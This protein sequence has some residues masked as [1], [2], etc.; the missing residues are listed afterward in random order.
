ML[1][2]DSFRQAGRVAGAGTCQ[3]LS[4]LSNAVIVVAIGRGSGAEGLGRFTLAFGAYLIVLGSTRALVSTP[5][6]TLRAR[7]KAGHPQLNS[8]ATA[9]IWLAVAGGAVCIL[10]GVGLRRSELVAVGLLLIPLCLQDL[11]RFAFFQIGQPWRAALVDAV[12][13]LVSLAVFQVITS[14]GSST[15]AMGLWGAGALISA[16]PG[17]RILRVRLVSPVVAYRWWRSEA[18]HLGI[19]L[20][21]ESFAFSVGSQVSLWVI[22]ALLGDGDLGRLKA[23]QTILGPAM[24]A[25]AGFTMLIVPQMAQSADRPSTGASLRMSGKALVLVGAIAGALIWIGPPVAQALF[26]SGLRLELALLIPVGAQVVAN[27]LAVGPTAAAMIHRRAG[28]LAI[29]RAVSMAIAVLAVAVCCGPLGIVGAAWALASG[30]FLFA[31]GMTATVPGA[32]RRLEG[33]AA[34]TD[35]QLMSAI[36][37]FV[38]GTDGSPLPA[39]PPD[40]ERWRPLVKK[41]WTPATGEPVDYCLLVMWAESRGVPDGV[42][43]ESA[44]AGL[45]QHPVDSWATRLDEAREWWSSRGLIPPPGN[46]VLDPE[47]NIAVAA[48]LWTIQ[49]WRPWAATEEWPRRE[50]SPQIRWLG[51]RYGKP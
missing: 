5:L 32:L 13:L 40:V 15:L 18:R 35:V 30:S 28:T 48:W 33:G 8:A 27:A 34:P 11:L 43:T 20:I 6:L 2:R 4:S 12:W 21:L 44:T 9:T 38:G 31:L 26:G 7:L 42:N 45:Y 51:D 25:L 16:V 49:G 10:I 17:I 3:V 14:R 1:V 36:A 39:H 24:M 37:G 29:M 47:L 41:Y 50:W 19:G 23:A 22:V 46:S